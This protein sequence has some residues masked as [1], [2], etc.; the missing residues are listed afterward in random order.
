MW[1]YLSASLMQTLQGKVSTAGDVHKYS[2][3][4]RVVEEDLLENEKIS[5]HMAAQTILKEIFKQ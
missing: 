3:I 5:G 2:E 4:V 1:K